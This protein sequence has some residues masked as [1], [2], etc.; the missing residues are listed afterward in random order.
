MKIA[1]DGPA[2][3]GKSTVAKRVAAQLGF[4]HIDTGAF[5]R[6]ITYYALTKH[7][8]LTDASALASLSET[9]DFTAIIDACIRTPEVAANVSTVAAIPEVRQHVVKKQ[10]ELAATYDVAMEGRDI[11]SVVFPNAELKIFLTAS[12]DERALRRYKEQL[13]KGITQALDEIKADIIRRDKADS[14]RA[15]SPLKKMPDAVELDTTGLTIDQ[16]VEKIVT[17]AKGR[18]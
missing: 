9:L 16:V 18:M 2:G 6:W 15:A 13:A 17:L 3:S 10:R 12:V 4:K 8:L 7:V 5:Y 14:T 11:G 1:I